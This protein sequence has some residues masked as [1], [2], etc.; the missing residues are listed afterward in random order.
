MSSRAR[1]SSNSNSRN[2]VR[3]PD[4]WC[5][6]PSKLL[7]FHRPTHAMFEFSPRIGLPG[8]AVLRLEDFRTEL[9][10]VCEGHARP[11]ASELAVLR[12]EAV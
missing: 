12:C 11:P 7:V 5:E 2:T 6:G 9:I 10:H 4:V 8:D 1:K 3:E